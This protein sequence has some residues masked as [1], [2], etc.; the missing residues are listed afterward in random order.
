[1]AFAVVSVKLV[2]SFVDDGGSRNTYTLWLPLPPL[3][4]YSNVLAY[5]DQAAALSQAISTASLDRYT[6]RVEAADDYAP[7][8][9]PGSDVSTGAVCIWATDQAD[10]RSLSYIPAFDPALLLAAPDPLAGIGVDTT[11]PAVQNLI[12]MVVTGNGVTSA[13][14]RFGGDIIGLNAAY[15]QIRP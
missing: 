11:Q 4:T 6:V 2:L 3:A 1:M 12:D 9:Q 7:L 5:A 8:A 10:Q 14:G 13:V 15:K